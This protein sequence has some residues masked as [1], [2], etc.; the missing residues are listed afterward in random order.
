MTIKPATTDGSERRAIA[1][2]P[3]LRA[4]TQGQDG[5]GTAAGY[6]VK[7]NSWT[8]IGGM[9]RERFAPGAFTNTLAADDQFAVHTHDMGR[10]V[11]RRGAG[12]LDLRQDDLG[13]AFENPLPDTTDGRDLAVSIDRGDIAD[14]SFA[15]IARRESWDE[16]VSP[17]ERTIYDAKLIE[18]SYLAAGAYSDTSVGLRSLEASRADTR[19]VHNSSGYLLRKAQQEQRIRRI[20]G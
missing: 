4:I 7:F 8:D 5:P 17:P 12:T 18:I 9:W 1:V 15:F 19:K 3:E 10:V 13:L 14:M 11:G 16:T 6:A 20:R 2:K